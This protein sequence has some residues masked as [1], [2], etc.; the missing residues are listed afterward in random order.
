MTKR[1][2]KTI[3]TENKDLFG[4]FL[5]KPYI[6]MNSHMFLSSVDI[7]WNDMK[8]T[9]PIHKLKTDEYNVKSKQML[10]KYNRWAEEIIEELG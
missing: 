4:G 5:L 9:A 6:G 10:E 7:V 8:L 1:R 2:L 3:L